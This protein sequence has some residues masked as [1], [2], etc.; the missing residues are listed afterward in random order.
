MAFIAQPDNKPAVIKSLAK[1]LRFPKVEPAVEGYES[2]PGLY[3]RAAHFRASMT[4]ATSLGCSG[5]PTRK[6]ANL[7]RKIW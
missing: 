7:K 2:L 6:F 5:P 4:S 3:E 1:G